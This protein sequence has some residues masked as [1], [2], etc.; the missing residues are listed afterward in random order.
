MPSKMHHKSIFSR[1]VV[2]IRTLIKSHI[3]VLSLISLVAQNIEY[4]LTTF[5]CVCVCV[6]VLVCVRLPCVCAPRAC[7]IY[8]YTTRA[9]VYIY[10]YIYTYIY[11]LC[12][13]RMV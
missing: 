5:V 6:C 3:I 12:S 10:I 9:R 11:E 8:I 2:F 13:V 4:L 7:C 1:I